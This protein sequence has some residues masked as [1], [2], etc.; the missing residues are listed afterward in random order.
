MI[1]LISQV[2]D[3]GTIVEFD[4][5]HFLLQQREGHFTSM[6]Q[7]TGKVMASQLHAT[8]ENAYLKINK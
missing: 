7:Q 1:Y 5:P 6:I 3:A 4:H 2:L 8:A